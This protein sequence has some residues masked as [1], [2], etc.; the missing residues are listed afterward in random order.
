MGQDEDRRPRQVNELE[1]FPYKTFSDLKKAAS[2]GAA[3]ISVHSGV[4]LQWV[5]VEGPCSGSKA[6]LSPLQNLQI[7]LLSLL[8]FGA[9]IGIIIYIAMTGSWLLLTSLPLLFIG[10]TIFFHDPAKQTFYK[11]EAIQRARKMSFFRHAF[12]LVTLAGLAWGLFGNIAWLT[13]LTVSISIVCFA[14]RAVNLMS[15]E[16]LTRAVWGNEEL[17]CSLWDAGALCIRLSSGDIYLADCKKESGEYSYF[18]RSFKD[19]V[20]QQI[21]PLQTVLLASISQAPSRLLWKIEKRNLWLRKPYN[22]AS[23]QLATRRLRS[24]EVY[25]GRSRSFNSRGVSVFDGRSQ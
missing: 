17:L 19:R 10:F 24:H 25:Q 7:F 12:L 14:Q 22:H 20:F 6:G 15:I 11:A 21:R 16:W 2:A 1:H 5:R 9:G 13:A 3:T 8:P 23:Y 18:K 4:P